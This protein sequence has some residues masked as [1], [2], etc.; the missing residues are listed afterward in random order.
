[1]N[2][3]QQPNATIAL[4]AIVHLTSGQAQRDKKSPQR[5]KAGLV[6][7]GP[8]LLRRAHARHHLRHQQQPRPDALPPDFVINVIRA[9]AV[10][11]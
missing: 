4:N 11:V 7:S 3:P 9:A 2:E 6:P 8:R 1:M 5:D 10:G